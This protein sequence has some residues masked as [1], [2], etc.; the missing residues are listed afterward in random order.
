VI[1]SLAGVYE[2]M[3]E[4]ARAKTLY[5]ELLNACSGCGRRADVHLKR[6]FADTSYA[7]GERSVT[8]LELYL[9]LAGED[10]FNRGPYYE[11]VAAIYREL[12]NETEAARFQ[13]FSEKEQRLPSELEP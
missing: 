10:P 6:R 1:R 12:G 4:T 11:R 7:L 3:G 8:V 2:A 5:G 9:G 13:R